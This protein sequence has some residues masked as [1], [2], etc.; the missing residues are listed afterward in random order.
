M[1]PDDI[2]AAC[3]HAAGR[4]RERA[5]YLA[6]RGEGPAM[7]EYQFGRA[8]ALE[9]L[10]MLLRADQ[11]DYEHRLAELATPAAYLGGPDQPA[12]G[13][14]EGPHGRLAAA[15]GIEPV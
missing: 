7:V 1:N 13:W 9:Q 6:S 4:A 11:A 10:A 14:Q 5:R 12:P 2:A 15:H 8:A 3:D